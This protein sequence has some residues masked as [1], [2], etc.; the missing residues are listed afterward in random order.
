MFISSKLAFLMRPVCLPILH[1]IL[2]LELKLDIAGDPG[3]L[4]FV[5]DALRLKL[6]GVSSPFGKETPLDSKRSV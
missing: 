1:Q 6:L 4:E 5:S 3:A 2:P